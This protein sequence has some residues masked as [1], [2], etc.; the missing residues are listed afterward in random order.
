MNV[1]RLLAR[2]AAEESD[3]RLYGADALASTDVRNV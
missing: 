2:I 1:L 3:L